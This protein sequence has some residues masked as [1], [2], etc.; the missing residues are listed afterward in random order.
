MASSRSHHH[1]ASGQSLLEVIVALGVIITGLV[2]T[3]MLIIY[4]LAALNVSE[5][6]VVATNLAREGIEVVRSI[7]D[8][9]WLAMESGVSG[10][11]WNDGL[12]TVTND[13]YSGVITFSPATNWAL[14]L[15]AANAITDPKAVIYTA[16]ADGYFSQFASPP[17]PDDFTATQFRRLLTVLPIC[18]DMTVPNPQPEVVL[19]TGT[20]GSL[21][22]LYRQV[23]VEVRSRVDWVERNRTHSAQ[24][25]DRLFDWKV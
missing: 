7:R 12:H 9:N 13:D 23:G 5:S 3:V 20:C 17:D 8:D 14:D 1:H 10:A 15:T 11:A 18:R 21:G 19:S 16:N 25:V 24:V 6:Q 22:A 2:G 4:T